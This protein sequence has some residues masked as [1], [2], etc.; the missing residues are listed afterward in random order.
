MFAAFKQ[1][2]EPVKY[3]VEFSFHSLDTRVDQ[4]LVVV[5][6]QSSCLLGSHGESLAKRVQ[7][8][9]QRAF[10]V[11]QRPVCAHRENINAVLDL[12]LLLGWTLA[13][14]VLLVFRSACQLVKV[15]FIL[16]QSA[17]ESVYPSEELS[18]GR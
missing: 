10:G 7:N 2:L 13:S 18:D 6:E 12:L 8:S 15:Y 16:S 9:F 17:T 11:V 5:R 4:E 14:F 1:A 3:R